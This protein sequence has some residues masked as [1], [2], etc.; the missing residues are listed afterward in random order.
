MSTAALN[1]DRLRQIAILVS[2]VDSV[3]ARQLLSHLSPAT[4]RQVLEISKQLGPISAEEKHQILTAFQQSAS[5][6]PASSHQ[7]REASEF[8]D[9]QAQGTANNSSHGNTSELSQNDTD[10]V[11]PQSKQSPWAKLEKKV[12]LRFL[13][14]ERPNVIAVVVSQLDTKTSISILQELGTELSCKVLQ[15]LATL[16]D[17]DPIAKAAIEEHLT[18][19]I[20]QHED[21]IQNESENARRIEALLTEAPV[22]LRSQ[23][24]LA[25]GLDLGPSNSHRNASEEQAALGNSEDPP[26]EFG[27]QPG[28]PHWTDISS[29]VSAATIA[30][31][32]NDQWKL[33]AVEPS[34][35]AARSEPGQSSPTAASPDL[36]QL[37]QSDQEH[38]DSLD[39]SMIQFEFERLLDLPH[40]VLAQVLS[41]AGTR[42]VLISLSGAT[43]RFINKL[44][45]MLKRR[46]RLAL[47]K[48]IKQIEA[49]S[50][51]DIADAQQQL[52]VVANSVLKQLGELHGS[53]R[54]AA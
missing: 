46:D 15:C 8:D 22:E 49:A 40:H 5:V 54:R 31:P 36:L 37:G 34:P 26:M 32:A 14:S 41:T 11:T 51:G 1:V 38:V 12:L 27:G 45:R 52:I 13:V 50:A 18:E 17:I 24:R 19:R 25:M 42:S 44:Y 30:F 20:G 29:P 21:R 28:S 7:V 16:G 39:R 2:L 53:S 48:R 47:D 10:A 6:R 23:W 33:D 4:A 3:A 9:A 43:P 35:L